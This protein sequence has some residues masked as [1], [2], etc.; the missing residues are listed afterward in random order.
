MLYSRRCCSN[1]HEGISKSLIRDTLLTSELESVRFLP[2][3]LRGYSFHGQ[4]KHCPPFSTFPCSCSSLA[5]WYSY[6]TL[7]SPISSSYCHGS[8]FARLSTDASQSCQSFATTAHTT[9][10]SRCLRGILLLEYSFS[11]FGLLRGSH[12]CIGAPVNIFISW[13]GD[14]ASGGCRACRRP[15][16]KP[17]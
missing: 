4:S 1:G 5:W 10:R 2:K 11:H 8:A 9:P 17:L 13:L 7:I 12:F 3:E 14:M 15:S 16:R 6:G